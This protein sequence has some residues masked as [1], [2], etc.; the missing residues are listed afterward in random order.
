MNRRHHL[1]SLSDDLAVSLVLPCSFIK[2]LYKRRIDFSQFRLSRAGSTACG[3]TRGFLFGFVRLDL[4]FPIFLS[5]RQNE[6]LQLINDFRICSFGT[7]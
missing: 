4:Q 7:R 1:L 6:F 2:L 5:K 3:K